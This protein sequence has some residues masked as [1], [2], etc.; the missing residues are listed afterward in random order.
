[1]NYFSGKPPRE[2]ISRVKYFWE[3]SAE[4][5]IAWNIFQPVRV[6]H[7]CVPCVPS[8]RPCKGRGWGWGM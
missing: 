5:K 1:M 4:E 7:F 8:P 6:N 2:K 3:G